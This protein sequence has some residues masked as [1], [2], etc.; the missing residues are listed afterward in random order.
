MGPFCS[1]LDLNMHIGIVCK[2]IDNYGDAGFSL[3]LAKSLAL[4][5]HK[6]TLFHDHQATF[7]ALYPHATVSGLTL[8]DAT[9]DVL[10]ADEHA[11][12]D[13]ILEPFG[14][15]SEQT[16]HRFDLLLK[17]GFPETPWLLIDY[18]SAEE[19][20]ESFHLSN[21]VDPKSGHLTTFFYP[22]FTAKTGGLIHCD[23]PKHLIRNSNRQLN[24]QIKL[25]V[26][27]YPNAPLAQ[28]L[29]A[30]DG[31]NTAGSD[32]QVGLAGR[33]R[34][35]EYSDWVTEIPFCPQNEFDELLVQFD[36]LF[37]RGEDSFVRAQLAGKPLIWQIYP[38]D[39]LAHTEKLMSFFKRYS[40]KLSTD[41]ASALWNC[42]ASWNCLEQAGEFPESWK[43]L[44]AHWLE[45]NAHALE[46]RD[47][48]MNGPELVKE[49][50]IWHRAKTPTLI[51]KTDL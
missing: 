14:S 6:V 7:Q 37:V 43:N 36:V 38:T 33:T 48:L 27:S 39:D 51:K 19:W 20:V 8:F 16:E 15:S 2:V 4:Q 17:Q 23:Y 28:L 3:R 41:C 45:L 22:G 18:L 35:E 32:I 46:W 1:W 21:S 31:L 5:G 49:V 11:S 10:R 47:Q 44:Q 29:L 40:A 9:Q 25:F 34:P 24:K 12:L 42:W 50:L 26:F 30:S 13:L